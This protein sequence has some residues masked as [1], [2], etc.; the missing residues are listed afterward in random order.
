IEEMGAKH[1]A[2]NHGEVVID[3]ENRL[4]TTPCYMLDARVDQIAAGAENLVSAMLDMI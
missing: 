4:V 3:K 2:S 1:A